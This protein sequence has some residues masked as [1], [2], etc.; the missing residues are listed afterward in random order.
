MLG[1]GIVIALFGELLDPDRFL[2]ARDIPL[3][4]LPLRSIFSSVSRAGIPWWNPTINGGQPILSNPS[5][6]AFYPPSWLGLVFAPHYALNLQV[7]LH[8]LI[9]FVGAWKLAERLGCRPPASLLAGIAFL[10][11]GGY[12]SMLHAIGLFFSMSWIPWI[13]LNG[14]KLLQ[15]SRESTKRRWLRHAVL[16]ASAMACQILIGEPVGVLL[17]G[18]AFLALTAGAARRYPRLVVRSLLPVVLAIGFAGVQL[19]PTLFRLAE[20][21]RALSLPSEEKT[22]WSTSPSRLVEIIYPRINGNPAPSGVLA[23][24]DTLEIA[25]QRFHFRIVGGASDGA[26]SSG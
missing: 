24:G 18:L 9:A 8:A 3:F 12:L 2:T 20:A 13:L 11:S 1:C 25:G 15:E 21:P 19:V 22:D 4:H 6:S 5:Y 16:T 26:G 7:L 14:D 10:G 23:D 17:G